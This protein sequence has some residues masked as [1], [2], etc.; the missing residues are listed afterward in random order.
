MACDQP[1]FIIVARESV[2]SL[3]QFLDG[4]KDADPQQVL[5]EGADEAL[6]DAIA[7]GFADEGR[8]GF[9]A[10]TTDFVLEVARHIV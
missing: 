1:V 8:R 4:V 3:A 6:G 7:L 2:E 9:D 10:Q 5:L